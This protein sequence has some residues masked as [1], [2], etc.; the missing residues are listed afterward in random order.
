MLLEAVQQ[1]LPGQKQRASLATSC[2]CGIPL[3]DIHRNP[4]QLFELWDPFQN[5]QAESNP[6]CGS[7]GIP[8]MAEEHMPA[9]AV[10]GSIKWTQHW[11]SSTARI[12]AVLLAE[13]TTATGC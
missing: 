1:S 4:V 9:K 8:E 12:R 10:S 13:L 11:I 3:V 7:A 2:F 5:L 6:T